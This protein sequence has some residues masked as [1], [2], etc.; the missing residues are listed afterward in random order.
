VEYIRFGINSGADVN[1]SVTTLFPVS[2]AFTHYASRFV[3]PAVGFALGWNYW[4]SYAITLPTEITAAAL[5]IDYW[6]GGANV[7]VAVWISLFLVACCSFNFL[8]VR[9][10]GEAEFW[11]SVIKITTIIGLI[12]L[13]IIIS[14]G[15][16]PTGEVTG[17]KV[18]HSVLSFPFLSF[19]FSFFRFDNSTLAYHAPPVDSIGVHHRSNNT[20]T[21]NYLI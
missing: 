10:Y 13:G 20:P 12:I 5:V 15:G 8:G 11:F 2:G 16:G 9:Y 3:D 19:F 17:F 18:R 7:N 14:A 4:Y 21:V 1:P 6:P